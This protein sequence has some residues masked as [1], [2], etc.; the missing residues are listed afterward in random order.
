MSYVDKA[1]FNEEPGSLVYS[2]IDRVNYGLLLL[3]EMSVDT[4][5]DKIPPACGQEQSKQVKFQADLVD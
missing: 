5:P 1:L 2:A 3:Q 4:S